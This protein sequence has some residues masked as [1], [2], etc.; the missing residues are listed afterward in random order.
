MRKELKL[1]PWLTAELSLAA[2]RD[3][4]ELPITHELLLQYC[5]FGLCD[6]YVFI[7]GTPGWCAD[8]ALPKEERGWT[9]DCFAVGPQRLI[10]L[11]SL[12]DT[13]TSKDRILLLGSVR[14]D[15][16]PEA[17]TYQD[18]EWYTSS[19][20]PPPLYF[21]QED[22]FGLAKKLT[23]DTETAAELDP[24]E[25]NSVSQIIAV[26]ADMAGVDIKHPYAQFEAM[27]KHAASAGIRFSLRD[28]TVA[29]FFGRAVEDQNK[30]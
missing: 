13:A 23:E 16:D 26:L 12:I 2:L 21:K 14:T 24:R 4:T 7:E 5:H 22:I 10:G 17:A 28:A 27:A 1:L 8:G 19:A 25:K 11:S 9:T 30:S 6:A 20:T 18:V 3:I 29:K 15:Q